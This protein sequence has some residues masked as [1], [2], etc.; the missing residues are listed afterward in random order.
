MAL[1]GS[2]G[3]RYA[4]AL[5]AAARDAGA[6]EA[7]GRD[8]AAVAGLLAEAP[9]LGAALSNP[10]HRVEGRLGVVDAVAERLGAH[11]LTRNFLRLLVEKDRFDRFAGI[12][13]A[14]QILDDEA[15]GRVRATL[16][17]AVPLADDVAGEVRTKL[18]RATGKQVLLDRRVDPTLVG[19]VVT[20]I[21]SQ[22][23]DGS[24]RTQIRRV[25]EQLQKG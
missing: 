15:A 14:F 25:R 2:I 16:T 11:A 12:F 8:L 17:S 5:F 19:G 4:R 22:V 24:V 10:T 3:R 23:Y 6:L 20:R 18:E 1:V 7:V 21:G 13:D 9:D